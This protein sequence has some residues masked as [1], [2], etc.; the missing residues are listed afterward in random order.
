LGATYLVLFSAS[1][2]FCFVFRF[3]GFGALQA[4][5]A[6]QKLQDTRDIHEPLLGKD[7]QEGDEEQGVIAVEQ[8]T[9]KLLPPNA[10]EEEEKENQGD[11]GYHKHLEK[12]QGENGYK[13]HLQF[14]EEQGY[15]GFQKPASLVVEDE[16]KGVVAAE[17]EEE[18]E[19]I[20]AE[21]VMTWEEYWEWVKAETRCYAN[22]IC[23]VLIVNACIVTLIILYFLG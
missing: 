23:P 22:Y 19:K 1:V 15:L 11:S 5:M 13:K 9:H 21:R 10:G 6:D 18:E 8:E 4:R 14:Y 20:G 3:W 12:N 7:Q 16:E 2:F 17:E